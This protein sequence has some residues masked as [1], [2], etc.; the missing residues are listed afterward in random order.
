MEQALLPDYRFRVV[1][2]L[3]QLVK[4]DFTLVTSLERADGAIRVHQ[5]SLACCTVT[6]RLIRCDES[7]K[8]L[9]VA[10]Y[11][12]DQPTVSTCQAS[13]HTQESPDLSS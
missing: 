2:M 8:L 11:S 7:K 3:P 5:S 6:D 12:M 4:L 1:A 9:G 10:R 13:T